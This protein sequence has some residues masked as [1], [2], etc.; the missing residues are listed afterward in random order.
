MPNSRYE[1]EPLVNEHC[2]CGE[3]PLWNAR[4]KKVYWTDIPNGV[5]F[6]YDTR[7]DE[8]E[9]IYDDE[10]VGGFTF[11]TDG[12]LLLF[13][14]HNI[15]VLS[16]DGQVEVLT[17]DIPAEV[18]RF[19]DVIADAE[20]RVYAGTGGDA[21]CTMCCGV[22]RVDFNGSVTPLFEGTT[23]SN[24]MGFTPDGKQMYWTD[25]T[26]R[27]IF[28][29]DYDRATGELSNRR[30]FYSSPD[31]AIPDGMSVDEEGCVWSAQWDG[32]TV[33]HLDPDGK[34]IERIAFPVAQVSSCVFGGDNLDELYVTTAGGTATK[35][36]EYDKSTP[37]GTLYRVRV[38]VRGLPENRSRIGL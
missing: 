17:R 22:L 11:Q 32:W 15:A 26:A 23:C 35:G 25:S 33:L 2:K 34:L 10:L 16:E 1:L 19:N 4:D 24:G 3:N 31:E 13:R 14:D 20:G 37:D 8:H 5:I 38:G 7:S 28:L 21:S 36:A 27:K 30:E 12:S 18:G 6:R 9:K 29:Y